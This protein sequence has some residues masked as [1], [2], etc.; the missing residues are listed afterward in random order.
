MNTVSVPVKSALASKI[1]WLQLIGLAST[2]ATGVVGAFNMDPV[3]ATKVT[4]A[5]AMAVQV[6]TFIAR[7]FFTNSVTV[8][9]AKRMEG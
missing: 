4:A 5:V 1:N 8:S 2:I 9:S 7:T 6:A 3:T